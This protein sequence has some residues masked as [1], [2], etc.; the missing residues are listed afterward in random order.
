[1]GVC[2]NSRGVQ[3]QTV[4]GCENWTPHTVLVLTQK[5]KLRVILKPSNSPAGNTFQRN[6]NSSTQ[7]I[8][9]HISYL[10]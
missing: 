2:K 3:K 6:K 7:K 10:W 4:R 8:N 9:A 1:M 5:L